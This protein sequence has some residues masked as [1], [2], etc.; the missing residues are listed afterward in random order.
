MAKWH[1][2]EYI[3]PGWKKTLCVVYTK[4][5]AL[6]NDL[7]TLADD[8]TAILYYCSVLKC[9]PTDQFKK[10]LNNLER[11]RILLLWDNEDERKS[12]GSGRNL[13]TG[14][15]RYKDEL[16]PITLVELQNYIE[17]FVQSILPILEPYIKEYQNKDTNTYLHDIPASIEMVKKCIESHT[18]NGLYTEI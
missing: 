15:I 6:L 11:I 18:F 2:K 4:N 3:H 17:C 8:A 16:P 12:W 14:R 10:L 13:F 5:N 9:K 7:F 1:W